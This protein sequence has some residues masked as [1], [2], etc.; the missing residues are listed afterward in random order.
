MCFFSHFN[1]SKEKKTFNKIIKM[2]SATTIKTLAEMRIK[3][4][5]KCSRTKMK[6]KKK[7]QM[8]RRKAQKYCRKH[9]STKSI[10]YLLIRLP[11]KASFWFLFA[12]LDEHNNHNF[13]AYTQN[14]YC[15]MYMWTQWAHNPLRRETHFIYI[16]LLFLKHNAICHFYNNNDNSFRKQRWHQHSLYIHTRKLHIFYETLSR[17]LV[18]FPS[19]HLMFNFISSQPT[20]F[21]G[22]RKKLRM[23]NRSLCSF[24]NDIIIQCHMPK[25]QINVGHTTHRHWENVE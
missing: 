24:V 5:I 19:K 16:L 9:L 12:Q 23:V 4:K 15:T 13:R 11:L 1:S 21:W 3:L 20:I 22:W 10:I 2:P 14:V 7:K 17:Q 18:G 8:A 6:M 25:R